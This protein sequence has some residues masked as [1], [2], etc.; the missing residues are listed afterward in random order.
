MID[1][2]G[3]A[4]L[5]MDGHRSIVAAPGTSFAGYL[6]S[7]VKGDLGDRCYLAPELQQPKN[8]GMDKVLITKESDIY[9]MAMVIYEARSHKP[10]SY[11]SGSNLMLLP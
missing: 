4:R 2:G 10:I 5:A 7:S 1:K 11:G 6:Q 9:G 8:H 3:N